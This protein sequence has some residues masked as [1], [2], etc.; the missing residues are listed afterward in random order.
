M[1][2]ETNIVPTK[3]I[4]LPERDPTITERGRGKGKG[5]EVCAIVYHPS[6]KKSFDWRLKTRPDM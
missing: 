6:T 5:I 3:S 1:I 2:K 4:T